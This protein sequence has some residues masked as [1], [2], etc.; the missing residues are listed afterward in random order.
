MGLSIAYK[1]FVCTQGFVTIEQE[2]PIPDQYP[3]YF[4]R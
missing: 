2:K 1:D 3:S 4:S